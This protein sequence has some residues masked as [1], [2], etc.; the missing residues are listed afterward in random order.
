MLWSL[1]LSV[2]AFQVAVSRRPA[3]QRSVSFVG[4]MNA[5]RLSK[6]PLS[7]HNIVDAEFERGSDDNSRRNSTTATAPA[8]DDDRVSKSLFQLSLESGDPRWKEA[9]IPFVDTAKGMV[10]DG[11]LA[12]IVNVEGVEYGIA[13]PCDAAAAIT[14]EDS[15]GSVI[16][17]YPEDDEAEEIMEI[18]AGQLVEHVGS[19]LALKRTPKVLT[20]QG[21]LD[22]YTKDWQDTLLNTPYSTEELLKDDEDESVE[23]FHEFMRKELGEE[24]YQ[25]TMNEPDTAES[26]GEDIMALFDIP[27]IG[28]RSGDDEGL[29]AL[30]QSLQDQ[31]DP[32]SAEM[33]AKAGLSDP[34]DYD[35]A[36]LKLISFNFK[37]G[38]AY[39]LV[40]LLKPYTLVGRL[41]KGDRPEGIQF[42]LLT[43][44]EERLVIPKIEEVCKKDLDAAGLS[45]AP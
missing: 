35:S 23:W 11:T 14:F 30:I 40:Q 13:V 32:M 27:G 34:L 22:K 12:F 36:A 43:R 16:N 9:R 3:Y 6:L 39:S 19:D 42:E 31:E 28:E 4:P 2:D 37:D 15:D 18:M 21:G 17:Y 8:L 5:R 33:M 38:K 24:E 25:K 45:L 10:I 29:E 44:E 7:S 26:I 1:G 20:I 41:M